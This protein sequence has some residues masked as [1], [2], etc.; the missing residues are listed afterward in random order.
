MWT[1]K[2]FKAKPKQ[3][4]FLSSGQGVVEVT[5]IYADDENLANAIELM[6]FESDRIQFQVCDQCGF[7]GCTSG[8]WLSIRKIGELVLLLPAFR[9][10]DRG[11]WEASEYYPSYFTK[12]KGSI[13]MDNQKYRELVGLISKLP[14]IETITS[15]SSYEI[16]RLLQWEAPF[17]VLGDYPRPITFRRELLS[18]TAFPD[19]DKVVQE[20]M[21]VLR[22]FERDDIAYEL[23]SIAEDD[24]RFLFFL[25]A[26]S[27]VE[28][29]PLVRKSDKRYGL[30]LK[31]SH[32]VVA[33]KQG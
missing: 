6:D 3:M 17:R 4:D 15:A 16:A 12:V 26:S 7:P 18:S 8:N 25:D 14:S 5:A 31:N 9:E 21:E 2:E 20:L 28:W 30:V 23:T 19:D 33:L 13:L 11:E 10:M 32:A 24:E 22:H 1:P 29:V 27:F